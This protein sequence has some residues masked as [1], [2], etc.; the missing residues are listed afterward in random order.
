M[1]K[2]DKSTILS[3]DFEK[4]HNGLKDDAHPNYNSSSNSHYFDIKMSLLYC[5]GGL[6]AYTEQRLCD[7]ELLDDANWDNENYSRTLTKEE[8]NS[9]QGDLEHFDESLK[10]KNGWSWSNFFIVSTHANCRIKGTR[11]I[12]DILKPDREGYEPLNYLEFDFESGVFIPKITLNDDEKKDVQYMIE[13]L[14]LNCIYSQRKVRL[15]EWK[16]RIELGLSAE[17]NEYVTAWQIT[18]KKL[19]EENA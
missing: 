18:L 1:R 11:K 2:I 8:K 13:T 4:W 3:K 19:E 16:E 12:R 14:G 9:I 6:C 15:K 10:E 5:Q 17:P 7:R